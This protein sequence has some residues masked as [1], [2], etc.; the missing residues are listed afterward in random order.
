MDDT[1]AG[2]RK[3]AVWLRAHRLVLDVY[4]FSRAFP[5]EERYGLTSQ[6]RRAAGSTPMNIAEGAS[7][8][9]I[10]S[11]ALSGDHAL[12]SAGEVDY[13]SLLAFDL[14][15]LD[16]SRCRQHGEQIRRIRGMLANLYQTLKRIQR[17][18]GSR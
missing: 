7:G 18:P 11:H 8:V 13:Q 2:C 4:R 6:L 9:S 1:G 14:G 12:R 5:V 15:Y 3:L 17:G 10:G 16:I